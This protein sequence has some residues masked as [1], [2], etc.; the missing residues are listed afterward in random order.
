M[1]HLS[2]TERR[3]L[4]ALKN[5][6][7]ASVT[8]L[9]ADLGVSRATVQAKLERLIRTGVIRRFTIETDASAD[10]EA[11]RAIM[12]IELEGTLARSVTVA[13]KR[14]PEIISLHT[15]NGTWDLVAQI[16]TSNPVEFDR[17]LREVREINGVLNSETSI[18]LNRASG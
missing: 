11:I 5:D 6:G 1:Q 15:T 9:S 12:M 13:L 18:L 2:P 7:R 10:I 8:N 16:E 17:A 4:A 14:L 3:L